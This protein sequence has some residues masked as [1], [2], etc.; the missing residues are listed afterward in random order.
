MSAEGVVREYETAAKDIEAM[1]AEMI[2]RVRQCE[3]MTRAGLAV[4]DEMKQTAARYR[5]EAKRLFL[6]IENCSLLTA[7][8]RNTC[9]ELKQK[10]AAPVGIDQ[11][12]KAKK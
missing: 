11:A 4:L 6:E 2:Q 7:E 5:E 10:I 1:G 3:E 9:S 12:P 8:V